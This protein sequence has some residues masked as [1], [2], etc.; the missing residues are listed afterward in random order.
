MI[1]WLGCY[2]QIIHRFIHY[3]RSSR[4]ELFCKKGALRNFAKFTGKHLC[5]SLFNK[6]IGLRPATLLKK[7]LWHRCFP[8][9]FAK[10]LRTPFLT[11]HL[12]WLLQCLGK[13]CFT[14]CT[15]LCLILLF[16]FTLKKVAKKGVA[17]NLKVWSDMKSKINHP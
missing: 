17:V 13:T 12:Q 8:K 3:L 14:R 2:F 11:E 15:S 5:Q 6:V 9:N 1:I 10:F 4:P 16:C 7:R